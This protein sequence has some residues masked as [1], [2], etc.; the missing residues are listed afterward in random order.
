MKLTKTVLITFFLIL[1]GVISYAWFTREEWST[2]KRCE[3]C[4]TLEPN[5]MQR[6][7]GSIKTLSDKSML[8]TEQKTGKSYKL[9]PCD[10]EC[11]NNLNKWFDKV[12]LVDK[13]IDKPFLFD[14]EGKL[15]TGKNEF[16]LE[17]VILIGADEK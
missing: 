11:E 15:E 16:L 10:V 6:L 7:V 9:K 4:D 17:S 2:R 3:K 8:F 5:D 12:G 14:I 13:A 1:I